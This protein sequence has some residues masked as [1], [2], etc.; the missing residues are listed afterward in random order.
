MWDPA[1]YHRFGDERSRPFHDLVARIGARQPRQIIDLGCGPGELTAGLAQRWP[2]AGITGLD[3]S[4][5]MIERANA[6]NQDERAT[7]EVADVSTWVPDGQVDAAR[8]QQHERRVAG[9]LVGGMPHHDLAGAGGGTLVTT[10][11]QT[12]PQQETGRQD[13]GGESSHWPA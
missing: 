10:G 3:S 13:G 4:P 8:R 6:D 12:G 1:V 2:G 11:R 5:E 7:Y 9:H